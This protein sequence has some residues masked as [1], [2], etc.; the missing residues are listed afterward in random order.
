MQT[1]PE[2]TMANIFQRDP[3]SILGFIQ[4]KVNELKKINQLWQ[5]EVPPP[6]SQYSRIANFRDHCLVVEIDSAAWAT[7]L[8]YLLPDLSKKLSQYPDL[9][10]LK[11]IEW[12]IQPPF[13][14]LTEKKQRTPALTVA[15]AQLLRAI[16][17]N[18][19]VESLKIALARLA[20]NT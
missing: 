5:V 10:T 1:H 14:S 15:N 20:N 7:R 3:E 13:Y 18:T 8:R 17:E 2:K 12:Y 9:H 6:L 11:Q 19:K 16:A 4:K